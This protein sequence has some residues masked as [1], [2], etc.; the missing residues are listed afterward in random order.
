M[1]EQVRSEEIRPMTLEESRAWFAKLR[2]RYSPDDLYGHM[3][4]QREDEIWW[5][6]AHGRTE[7]LSRAE[8]RWARQE[9][10]QGG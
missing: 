6:V 4:R 2:A 7:G 9:G 1:T 3:L 8:V 10:A 5:Q